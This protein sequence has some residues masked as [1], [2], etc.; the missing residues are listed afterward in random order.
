MA[1]YCK[2]PTVYQ[3][4]ATE[5]GAASLAMICAYH[6]RHIPLEQMRI[7]TG[8][9]RDGCSAVNIMRAAKRLGLECHGYKI[10]PQNLM[11]IELPCIIHWNFN[12]FLVL[13]GFRG[14]DVLL[15]D[16]AVGRRRIT[17][18]ELDEGFTGVAMTFRPTQEF[19][20]EK[21]QSRI[22]PLCRDRLRAMGPGLGLAAAAAV[23][24]ALLSLALPLFVRS[25]ADTLLASG[26]LSA[27]LLAAA[28][29]AL[30]GHAASVLALRLL[31]RRLSDR[32]HLESA[33]RFA[34]KLLR[35]PIAF[36]DQR[37]SADLVGRIANNDSVNTFLS[38]S[39]PLAAASLLTA[40]AA[41]VLMG[42]IHP[43]LALISALGVFAGAL[44]RHGAAEKEAGAAI[45]LE[46]DRSRL[47][48]ALC[49][50]IG[51]TAALKA[52][53]AQAAYSEKLC[54]YEAKAALQ[55]SEAD[56]LQAGASALPAALSLTIQAALIMAG[57]LA[58]S[59]GGM[60][61]GDLC[62][63][64]LLSSLFSSSAQEVLS[65]LRAGSALKAE[66][67]RVDDILRPDEDVPRSEQADKSAM[68][69]KLGGDL[70]CRNLRFG[71]S[72]LAEPL[73]RNC[74]F[75]VPPGGSIA[76]VGASGS[77][78]ST[79]G[80]LISGLHSPWSGEI[81]IDG[82]P[83]PSIPRPVLHA[84]IATVSQNAALFSGTIRENIRMWNPAVREEDIIRAAKDACIHE[85]ILGKPNGY[86]H[87]LTE[88]GSNLSGGQRQR[89]EIARA[90]A[91]NPTVL[92]LDE[93][94]SALD[95]ALE[96]QIIR[97]IRRRGCTCI[98]AAHRFSAVR[99]CDIIAVIEAGE[100]KE[101]GTHEELM[102]LG[103][104]YSR[105]MAAE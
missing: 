70:L 89:I 77:G 7:E 33:R 83:M 94:T 32:L 29:S 13:E 101:T 100:I 48:G 75:H 17:M 66:L 37:Y 71:Y 2:T 63:C 36:Y 69:G 26:S 30:F 31:L 98:M 39:L 18:H 28:C 40:A 52:S 4:E 24:S 35:M 44:F 91:A 104:L 84:S 47:T 23:V 72:H 102:R 88:G 65:L 53:G 11:Q 43:A 97:N 51:V 64:L 73:L 95:P 46:Q 12:H 82:V 50:G 61:A 19:V 103:G 93:A 105:F 87:V 58:L 54:G 8:V 67:E 60:T 57:S 68:Q 59:R 38:V 1:Q 56:A 41:I 90:L 22:L 81:L 34:A 49:A 14:E 78:K 20:H 45:R 27:K 79:I 74:S 3:M 15:N 5:C 80:R 9:S 62:A 25:A 21:K 86:D 55:E 92:I 99:Q 76:F 85:M 6:G 96:E 10:E 42:C 16:P